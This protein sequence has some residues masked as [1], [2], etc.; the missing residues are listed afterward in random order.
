MKDI[1]PIQKRKWYIALI[2]IIAISTLGISLAMVRSIGYSN[3]TDN[4]A[5]MVINYPSIRPIAAFLFLLIA[6]YHLIQLVVFRKESRLL[7][8]KHLI[9]ILLSVFASVFLILRG[10]TASA[11]PVACLIY[12]LTV[13]IGCVIST[14]RKRSKW[15]I[16]LSVVMLIVAL[17]GA[18]CVLIGGSDYPDGGKMG[19]I[20]SISM[21]FILVDVQAVASILP[22]AFSSIRMD[23]LKRIIKKT[24]ATEILFGIVLLIVAFS[25]ILPAFEDNMSNYGDALWYCF[26]IVTTIGFGDITATSLIG[27]IMSVILGIYGIIVVSLVTSIIVNFYGEMKKEE[28]DGASPYDG[29]AGERKEMKD[30]AVKDPAVK[31]PA[32]KDPAI[33]EEIEL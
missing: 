21:L 11:W 33:V 15:N 18:A 30:P 28:N 20:L 2:G 23:V 22:I 10:D 13:F 9:Y 27:R 5:D 6:I 8:I 14:I 16:L 3:D 31:D 24:Y 4:I 12:F 1:T 29:S 7:S 32:V 17:T 26:A 25:F 19:A